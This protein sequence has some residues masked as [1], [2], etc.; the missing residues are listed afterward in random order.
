MNC[1]NHI[2]SSMYSGNFSKRYSFKIS[3]NYVKNMI[4]SL[5]YLSKKELSAK[6]NQNFAQFQANWLLV[7]SLYSKGLFAAFSAAAD[8]FVSLCDVAPQ[9]YQ[10]THR[11]L[12]HNWKFCNITFIFTEHYI[13]LC[14]DIRTNH[15][16]CKH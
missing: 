4:F 9:V 2:F 10:D 14:S 3:G 12:P 8:I 16:R 13:F 1:I 7:F 11:R 6:V 5:A 15:L